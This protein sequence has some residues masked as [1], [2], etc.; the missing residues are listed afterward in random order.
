MRHRLR[1]ATGCFLL[2]LAL[3]P[4]II[5]IIAVGAAPSEAQTAGG[6]PLQAVLVRYADRLGLDATMVSEIKRLSKGYY[7][8]IVQIQKEMQP[9]SRS[10]SAV[11]QLNSPEEAE[12]MRLAE[13]LAPYHLAIQKV[14]LRSIL[15]F[16]AMLTPDQRDELARIQQELIRQAHASQRPQGGPPAAPVPGGPPPGAVGPPPGN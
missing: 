1:T 3:L 14:Q 5:A 7:E 15:R 4:G 2:P 16:R 10:L 6:P 12:V 8:E 11:L 13:E 9:I